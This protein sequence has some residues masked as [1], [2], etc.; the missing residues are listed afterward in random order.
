MRSLIRPIVIVIVIITSCWPV[1]TDRRPPLSPDPSEP[2][3]P[4]CV[5]TGAQCFCDP[6]CHGPTEPKVCLP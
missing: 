2:I 3:D 6:D 4:T 1:A 5:P